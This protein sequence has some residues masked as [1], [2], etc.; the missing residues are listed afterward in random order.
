METYK[1]VFDDEVRTF[2]DLLY[3]LIKNDTAII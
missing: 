3:H 2:H 1:N